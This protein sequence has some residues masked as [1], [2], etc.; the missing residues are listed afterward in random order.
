MATGNNL[1]LI[2]FYS[3]REE[4]A[5]TLTHAAGILIVVGGVSAL[6]VSILPSGLLNLTAVLIYSISLL[7]MYAASTLY[8]GVR[9]DSR[10]I[11]FRKFDHCAIYLLIAGTY[12]PLMLIA[13]NNLTGFILLAVI[14]GL[15]IAG[16]T[17][18]CFTLRSFYGLSVI[19]YCTM[20][21]LCMCCIKSLI[22][23]LTPLALGFLIAGGAIYTLGIIFYLINRPYSHTIWHIFVLLGSSLH[24]LTIYNLI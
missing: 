11:L 4:I 5:N 13:V 16:I 7:S 21:W 15:A 8:H 12:T 24:Y 23:G 22:N 20:G 10:K 3:H 17:L 18:K 1:P 19:L 6:I 14:W 2:H 9:S